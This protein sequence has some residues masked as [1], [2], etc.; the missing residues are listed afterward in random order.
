[1]L[2]TH[3]FNSTYPLPLPTFLSFPLFPFSSDEDSDD[4]DMRAA[5]EDKFSD[6]SSSSGSISRKGETMNV[7]VFKYLIF[8]NYS[9]PR[10]GPLRMRSHGHTGD[11]MPPD[12]KAQ[13]SLTLSMEGESD[14]G[15][16]LELHHGGASVDSSSAT[17]D[18]NV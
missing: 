15:L 8:G 12:L 3:P 11:L 9:Y 14:D 13:H 18:D 1:M 2:A 10:Q 5:D 17:G 16:G 7:G 6:T 4:D